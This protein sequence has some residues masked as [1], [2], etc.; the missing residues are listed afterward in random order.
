VVYDEPNS[1]EVEDFSMRITRQEIEDIIWR[2]R[3]WQTIYLRLRNEDLDWAQQIQPM[4]VL[5]V[6]DNGE[7]FYS[8]IYPNP[9]AQW[10]N[11]T[12]ETNVQG[13][14]LY[15]SV[16]NANWQEV[17]NQVSIGWSRVTFQNN[18]PR[19]IYAARI[20]DSS[21][22]RWNTDIQRFIVK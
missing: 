1:S 2:L 17:M 18:L 20:S 13:G 9:V 16:I 4:V 6:D 21:D 10:Q 22:G 7:A 3:P 8:I 15:I 14:P 11:L 12:I 5:T 19:G